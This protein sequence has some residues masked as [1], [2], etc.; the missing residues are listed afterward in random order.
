MVA[1]RNSGIGR[2]TVLSLAKRGATVITVRR[3]SE[4]SEEAGS[5]FAKESGNDKIAPVVQAD[6]RRTAANFLQQRA[7]VHVLRE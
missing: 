6:L 7:K 5:E 1:D 4:G 3:S 2:S